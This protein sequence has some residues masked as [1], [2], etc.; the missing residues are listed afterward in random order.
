MTVRLLLSLNQ[1]SICGL[2]LETLNTQKSHHGKSFTLAGI[3]TIWSESRPISLPR[4]ANHKSNGVGHGANQL[5]GSPKVFS[6]QSNETLLRRIYSS[7]PV[8]GWSP[9]RRAVSGCTDM[10]C[11]VLL[12]R[13]K[14][15][16]LDRREAKETRVN[17]W[18][19]NDKWFCVF[20]L[21][22][23]NC[24][25]HARLSCFSLWRWINQGALG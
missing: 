3:R 18:V 8:G 15:E 14:L 6:G 2:T 25:K 10:S 12:H 5:I 23:A 24:I 7:N 17:L 9:G 11:A 4:F 13:E 19:P 1:I 21:V 16:D 22:R 20:I